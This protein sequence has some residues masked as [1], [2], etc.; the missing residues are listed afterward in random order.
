MTDPLT[1]LV[2]L[3]SIREGRMAEPEQILEA[4]AARGFLGGEEA[5]WIEGQ[6]RA[7]ADLRLHALECTVEAELLR[8]NAAIAEREA[9]Q[10]RSHQ[11]SVARQQPGQPWPSVGSEHGRGGAHAAGPAP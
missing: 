11:H 5:P 10:D 4:I 8:G 1:I 6:R 7:L 2:V 3:G 9:E